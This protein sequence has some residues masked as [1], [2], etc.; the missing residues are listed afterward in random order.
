MNYYLEI[1]AYALLAAASPTTLLATL[2]VL[3]TERGRLNGIV[4]GAGF[5][6]GQAIGVG[7]P[8][9]VGVAVTSKTSQNGTV[10][11]GLELALGVLMVLGAYR[12]RRP[13][14]DRPMRGE[15][16]AAAVLSRLEHVDPKSAFTLGIPLGI[17]VKRL[18]L[19]ILAASTIALSA[20][21]QLGELQQGA[22]YIVIASVPVWLPV[23]VYF[24]VGARADDW[25]RISKAWLLANQREVTFYLALG[26]G[27]LFVVGG[28]VGLFA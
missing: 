12:L 18:V 13:K 8:L 27:L 5:I 3:G 19:S 28:I 17:G 20:S 7:V 16:R 6:L 2:V 14:R 25:V 15:S 9:F 4:F 22:T 10:T 26:F 23:M 21:G 24:V 11:A 1:F